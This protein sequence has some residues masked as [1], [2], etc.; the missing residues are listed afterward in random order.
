MNLNVTQAMAN[1]RR[2]MTD[3]AFQQAAGLV[4]D[5]KNAVREEMQEKTSS[6]IETIIESLQSGG[7]ITTEEVALMKAWIVGDA[8]GY[9]EMEN[10]FHD[11]LSEY[12]RLEESLA[13]YEGKNCSTED[14]SQLHGILEDATR[15]SYDIATFLEKQDRMKRFDS[16]VADGLDEDERAILARAL[17]EKLRSPNS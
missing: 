5:A 10:N 3:G 7:P 2:V 1:A 14:L 16:A 12:D 17:S 8:K 11:W 4:S 15:I 6:K 13:G 9:T